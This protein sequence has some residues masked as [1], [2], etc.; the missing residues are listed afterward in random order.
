MQRR[1]VGDAHPA[2][3]GAD[4]DGHAHDD[5]DDHSGVA[6]GRR[7]PRVP[8]E[9]GRLRPR[10]P[11]PRHRRPRA[12]LCRTGLQTVDDEI[13]Q[14][15]RDR[16]RARV[17]VTHDLTIVVISADHAAV[18]DYVADSS[19]DVDADTGADLEG[20]HTDRATT[21]QSTLQRV[22]GRW[23]VVFYT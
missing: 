22:D 13:D 20:P 15:V 17:S 10:H 19:V 4:E 2:D 11:D 21:F 9:L 5:Y 14:R 8:A 7:A 1:G 16:R 6:R 3:L 18:A 23:K 12:H